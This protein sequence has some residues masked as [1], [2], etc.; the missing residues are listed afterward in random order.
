MDVSLLRSPRVLGEELSCFSPTTKSQSHYSIKSDNTECSSFEDSASHGAT[1][2]RRPLSLSSLRT[3]LPPSVAL[4][5]KKRWIFSSQT[6][7]IY[8]FVNLISH[9]FLSSLNLAKIILCV[10]PK[11][12]PWPT[13]RKDGLTT[14]VSLS[15]QGV[16]TNTVVVQ[17]HPVIQRKGDRAV[18]L[19]CF[20][21]TGD[22]L[23]TN[24]YD[25][26]AE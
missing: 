19:F 13:S 18:Q 17:H 11:C 12:V 14:Y 3:L 2:D 16:Y 10:F 20:F 15:A 26:L 1:D 6:I 21:E 9:D 24:S 22:K 4:R 7:I 25:V 8:F 5:G 23:V